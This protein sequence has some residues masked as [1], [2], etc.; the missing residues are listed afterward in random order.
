M[1]LKLPVLQ[2]DDK[3]EEHM[4]KVE[5]ESLE[6]YDAIE[7]LSYYEN[8][9]EKQLLHIAE[10][11]LDN[12]EVCIGILD[13]LEKIDKR[14]VKKANAN[15]IKKLLERGWKFKKLLTIKED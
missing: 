2:K 9:T 10:E 3:W 6:L 4:D 5:E 15:H 8:I 12:I 13:K 1:E 14:I 7:A 11:A